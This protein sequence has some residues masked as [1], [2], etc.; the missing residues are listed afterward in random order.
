MRITHNSKGHFFRIPIDESFHTYGRLV[1]PYTFII[2]DYRTDVEE[3]DLEKIAQSDFLFYS[4]IHK[5]AYKEWKVIGVR[6]LEDKINLNKIVFFHQDKYDLYNCTK[7]SLDQ[8]TRIQCKPED[9]VGLQP[10][11]ISN[12]FNI[13]RRLKFHYEGKEDPQLK[14]FKLQLPK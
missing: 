7:I 13:Q 12:P 8:F 4:V 9:C 2:Y 14:L 10:L 11:T 6:D 3:T 1:A 5:S